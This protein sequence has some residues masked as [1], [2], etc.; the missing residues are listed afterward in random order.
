MRKG[1]VIEVS[2][3]GAE[4]WPVQKG[5]NKGG[6]GENTAGEATG[7][8]FNNVYVWQDIMKPISWCAN[9]TR[10]KNKQTIKCCLL[11]SQQRTNTNWP[12]LPFQ[13]PY[14]VV[15]WVFCLVWFWFV[16]FGGRQV[17]S[18]ILPFYLEAVY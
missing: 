13:L 4:G 2:G 5:A 1:R 3:H 15:L 11:P 14:P 17:M 7:T 16:C 6:T 9:L 18:V 8:K 12:D 10:M